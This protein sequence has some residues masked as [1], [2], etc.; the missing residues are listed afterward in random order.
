V[1]LLA[2]I[3]PLC[4]WAAPKAQFAA[5]VNLVEVYAT[6]TD[7]RGEPVQG[8]VSGDFTVA[9]D[10]VRQSIATFAAGAVPLSVAVGL[11]RSFS[12]GRE[13]L[14]LAV[15]ALR[16]FLGGLKAQDRLAVLAIGSDA[17]ILSPFTIDHAASLAALNGLEPWGTTPLYDGIVEALAI[18]QH[19]TGRRALVLLSDG[20]DRYSTATSAEVVNAARRRDVLIY[21]IALGRT[22][23]PI[24]AELASV[25]GGRSFH[26]TNQESLR[27]T[28][29][30]IARELR[31]QYLLGYAPEHS[32]SDAARWRS[33]HVTVNRPDLRVRA[34][35]GY[36]SR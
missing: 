28:L 7:G 24:F 13:W 3:V 12:M 17:A 20:A 8:L 1:L 31:F 33:I 23:A 15:G 19:E 25:S 9:E 10:G 2:W 11:D 30:A 6:V 36:F 27:T 21:P 5:G 4:G 18:T 32:S 22:R 29:S 26:A 35:D 34:R 14:A 16:E